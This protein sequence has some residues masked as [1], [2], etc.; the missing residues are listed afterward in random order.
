MFRYGTF[1]QL[2]S[3]CNT[4]QY[5][6]AAQ[7]DFITVPIVTSPTKGFGTEGQDVQINC[8]TKTHV[9]I[10]YVVEFFVNGTRVN[11]TAKYYISSPYL[12]EETNKTHRWDERQLTIR[13]AQISDSGRYTC[14]I[15]D[16]NGH[17]NERDIHIKIL[18]LNE[19]KLTFQTMS[20]T[21]TCTELSY[22]QFIVRYD[23]YPE[24]K[25]RIFHNEMQLMG[26]RDTTVVDIRRNVS[27]IIITRKEAATEDTGNYTIE[28]SNG[29]LTRNYTIQVFVRSKP[30]VHLVPSQIYVKLGQRGRLTC[31]VLGYPR[32]TIE[33]SFIKCA[34]RDWQFCTRNKA[35][36]NRGLPTTTNIL[37]MAARTAKP[38]EVNI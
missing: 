15:T 34:A 4:L 9:S 12:I 37:Y 21:I 13:R 20:N 5:L 17:S 30:L 38:N 8:T 29:Q 23:S 26:D 19:S 16:H 22:C 1:N 7:T 10:N 24:P 6:L 3:V 27:E 35:V 28:A 11:Q 32:S 14:R 2:T 36:S 18:K 25:F 31:N 33:W